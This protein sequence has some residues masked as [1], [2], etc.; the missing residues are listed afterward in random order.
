MRQ[1]IHME[2]PKLAVHESAVRAYELEREQ[3]PN[4]PKKKKKVPAR[5]QNP[6][7]DEHGM[8]HIPRRR[9]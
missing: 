7:K 1:M 2:E 5:W 8:Y 9:A 4:E 3:M 6:M